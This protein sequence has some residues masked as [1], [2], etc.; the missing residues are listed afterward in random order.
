MGM[1]A[2]V[3]RVLAKED[4]PSAAAVDDALVFERLN[5]C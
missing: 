5:E 1:A 3:L 4:S 2:V